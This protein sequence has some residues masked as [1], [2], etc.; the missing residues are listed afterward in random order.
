MSPAVLSQSLLLPIAPWRRPVAY[1][2]PFISSVRRPSNGLRKAS[3]R[4]SQVRNGTA[5]LITKPMAPALQDTC[6][7]MAARTQGWRWPLLYC[8]R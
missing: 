6:S 5:D 2:V 7:P 8:Q 1:C 4:H 3:S